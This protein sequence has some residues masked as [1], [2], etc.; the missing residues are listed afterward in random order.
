MRLSEDDVGDDPIPEVVRWVDEAVATRMVEPCA[1]QLATAGPTV[2]TVLL[3]SIDERGFMFVTNFES[4]KAR[5]LDADARCALALLW[6]PMQRQILVTGRAERVPPPEVEAY[7]GTRPRDRQV[8]AW[9]SPQSQV[10]ADRAE[11]ER[12]VDEVEARFAGV[13]QLPVPPNWGAYRVVPDSIELW[14]GSE[15]RLHDRLRWRRDAP[16]EPWIRERLAP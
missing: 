15:D 1:M 3:R 11:L 12:Y 14:C 4:R 2:R 9:A 10:L 6:A 7:W 16:G 8:A 5:A 13:E